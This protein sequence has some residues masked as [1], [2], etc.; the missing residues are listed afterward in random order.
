MA[1]RFVKKDNYFSITLY[2]YLH[3]HEQKKNKKTKSTTIDKI[4][5]SSSGKGSLQ[6]SRE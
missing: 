6:T 2:F 4:A 3:S 1:T 5:G